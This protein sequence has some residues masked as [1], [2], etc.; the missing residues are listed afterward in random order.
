MPGSCLPVA[1]T[2]A[3]MLAEWETQLQLVSV[4]RGLLSHLYAL[5]RHMAVLCMTGHRHKL[6]DGTSHVRTQVYSAAIVPAFCDLSDAARHSA[7]TA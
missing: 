6:L 5:H 1:S 7:D 2:C 3:C 4:E